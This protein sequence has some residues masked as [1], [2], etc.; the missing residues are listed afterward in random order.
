MFV[1]RPRVWVCFVSAPGIGCCA[2]YYALN[3]DTH[4]ARPRTA[5]GRGEG[6]SHT[7]NEP[8]PQTVFPLG[9]FDFVS[10]LPSACRVCVRGPPPQVQNLIDTH[11][12]QPLCVSGQKCEPPIR[13][14]QKVERLTDGK[15]GPGCCVGS[16]NAWDPTCLNLGTGSPVFT[17]QVF[18]VW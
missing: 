8:G 9:V 5:V 13:K 7:A 2:V 16:M 15:K 14:F 10:R 12:T 18:S 3:D 17:A 11:K 4:T 6:D 1:F